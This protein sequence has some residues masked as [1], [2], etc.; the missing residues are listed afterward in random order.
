MCGKF[1][2][3]PCEWGKSGLLFSAKNN[4]FAVKKT[5]SKTALAAILGQNVAVLALGPYPTGQ[6]LDKIFET[7]LF[8]IDVL[9]KI[10][11]HSVL[12]VLR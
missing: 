8:S 7:R 11:A 6:F 1:H 5:A 3:P 10:S 2:T 9:K 4:K 12:P